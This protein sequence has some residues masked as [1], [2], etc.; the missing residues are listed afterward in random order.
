MIDLDL[1][2]SAFNNMLTKTI[3]FFPQFLTTL[4][5]LVIGWLIAR[6]IAT[7]TRRLANRLH[8]GKLLEQTGVD[9]GLKKAG[10]E[11]SGSDLLAS[12]LFW[13]ILLNFLSIA[14]ENLGLTA[15]I[16]PL[17]DLIAYSPHLLAAL[18]TLV[19]GVLLAQFLGRA[20]QAAMSSMGVEFHREVG[21]GVNILLIIMV[22]IV[23]LEQLGIDAT[24]MTNL[25]TNV[26]TIIIAGLALT[27]GLGG[28]GAARN[29]LASYYAR[30]QFAPGDTLIIDGEEGTLEEIGTLNAK[31]RVSGGRL[32]IPNTRLTEMAVKIKDA[33][34]ESN[35]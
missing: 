9:A 34:E 10:I 24:V 28:R 26:L 7:L 23:V 12:L 18:A 5:I 13:I 19:I 6:L 27:F 4:L 29:I 21:Q 16:A 8:F 31:I 14:L 11:R 33:A 1:L 3:N 25:F 35:P 2:Q 15:A 32:I 30:E 22:I 20:A 17:R